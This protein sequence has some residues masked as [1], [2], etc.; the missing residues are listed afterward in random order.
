MKFMVGYDG[1]EAAD[2]AL[3][4]AIKYAKVFDAKLHVVSSLVG[5]PEMPKTEMDEAE[6][7]MEAALALCKRE[8]IPFE[9]HLLVRFMAPGEDIVQFAKENNIDQIF[10]GVKRR[11]KVGKLLF[12]SN[13]Q[14]VILEADCPVVTVK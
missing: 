2:E 14:Y 1:T 5:G 10:I 9:K 7:D 8:G 4:L 6:D 11:S 3:K 12:G 13:A